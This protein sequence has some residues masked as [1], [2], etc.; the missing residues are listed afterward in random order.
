MALVRCKDHFP[1]EGGRGADY[2]VA[3]ESIGYPETAAICGRKGHDKPGYVLLTESEYELYKQGQR[4]F[5]PH[6]NAAHV[7]VKDPVVK[8]I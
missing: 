2:K 5:E 1:E 3:V 7:R 6:T 8:E 4:V